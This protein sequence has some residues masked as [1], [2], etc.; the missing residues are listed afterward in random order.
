MRPT[1]QNRLGLGTGFLLVVKATK[2]GKRRRRGAQVMT[3]TAIHTHTQTSNV[4]NG[5]SSF[6]P[7][8]DR[9]PPAFFVSSHFVI[10]IFLQFNLPPSPKSKIT[11][12][13][14]PK[15]QTKRKETKKKRK[16]HHHQCEDRPG[17]R[18]GAVRSRAHSRPKK[19]RLKYL[20]EKE[21]EN[22]NGLSALTGLAGGC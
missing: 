17:W 7:L 12:S 2:V 3:Q 13:T 21:T 4:L 8:M 10:S 20:K 15:N 11:T 6:S 16:K 14:R 5:T 9:Q 19:K 1:S 18:G 22:K